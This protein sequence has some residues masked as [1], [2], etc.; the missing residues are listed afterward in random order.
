M[1]AKIAERVS[2]DRDY[3]LAILASKSWGLNT[4]YIFG[5]TFLRVFKETGNFSKALEAEK[6]QMKKML[7]DPVKLQIGIMKFYGFSSFDPEDYMRLYREKMFEYVK[8]ALGDVHIAN[9][10]MLPTH[11]G[12]IGHHIGWQYYHICR[13]EANM[14]LLRIHFSFLK[15][16]LYAA[17]ETGHIKSV[18][19]ISYFATGLSSVLLYRIIWDEG[20]T[21]EMPDCS[22]RGF[23]TT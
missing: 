20:F 17:Y 2:T 16:N 14:E 10:A 13:D 8:D 11:V 9:I 4:S 3:I 18:F 15:K 23:T 6:E 12:D 7:L 22:P 19:D 5:N 21:A 1:L